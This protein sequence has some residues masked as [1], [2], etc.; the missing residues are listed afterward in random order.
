M[1][2]KKIRIL[3]VN[4][5]YYPFTGG[6]EQVVRQI[7]E[8]LSDCTDM[9]VL[10]CS[11]GGKA[12]DEMIHHVKI[13]RAASIGMIGNLPIPVNLVS[14]LRTLAKEADIIQFH[15]PFPFGDLAGLLSGYHG[16]IVIWW[17]SDVVRQKKM[18]FFYKPIM[19]KFLKR[20][21]RIIVATKGHIEGSVYLQ[22]YRNKCVVIPFGVKEELEH[23]ADQYWEEYLK[24]ESSQKETGLSFLFVGRFV[25]YKGCDVLLEAF[26]DLLGESELPHRLIM[27]GSGP[28]EKELREL[29]VRKKLLDSVEFTGTVSGERL[30]QKFETCDVFVL[31]SV[32][33]SE[34]F[35]LVQIEAMAFG[36]PVI[37]TRLD[38]G[39][40]YVSLDKVTGLT[41]PPG[42]K[43]ALK[44][45]MH[46]MEQHPEERK[47]MGNMGRQRM[48]Q[49]YREKKML[50]RLKKLYEELLEEDRKE[51]AY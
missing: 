14:Q 36:K 6:I 16:K 22:P 15:M 7:A 18:M 1:K 45:A 34:A 51:R 37:N 31:P 38:S 2:K 43:K 12:K 11:E 25:Y 41:I 26:A 44:E 24:K 47:R 30:Y 29:A 35:G 8:G 23:R 5:L 50:E 9:R 13:Y 28:M 19:E 46:Y 21:D 39:V 10:V 27:V 32:A 33:R 4:K 40:P 48:K 17:H 42:D 49:E 3:Q 20:A